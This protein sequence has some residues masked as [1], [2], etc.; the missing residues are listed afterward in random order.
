MKREV[1]SSCKRQPLD[2][3]N[4]RLL[5]HSDA[6]SP[7]LEASFWR[8]PALSSPKDYFFHLRISSSPCWFRPWLPGW[9]E[10]LCLRLVQHLTKY[11][12]EETSGKAPLMWYNW[13][14]EG[15]AKASFINL[16]LIL[17]SLCPKTSKSE[18]THLVKNP[19]AMQET[20]VKSLGWED[21]LEKGTAI[22]SSI[23]SWRIPW[24]EEPGGLQSM[25]LQRVRH[26]WVTNTNSATC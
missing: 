10:S 23:L 26:D 18:V 21:S 8:V 19:P 16:Y 4:R 15:L 1:S 13:V 6:L 17:F 25:G 3:T 22:L 14:G 11:Q 20:Q 5:I 12:G 7:K 9:A 24:T 2:S